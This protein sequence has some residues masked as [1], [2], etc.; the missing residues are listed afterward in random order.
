MGYSAPTRLQVIGEQDKQR[1]RRQRELLAEL[2]ELAGKS[3][4]LRPKDVAQFLNVN[5]SHI[6]TLVRNGQLP[7]VKVGG[8]Y[9]VPVTWFAEWL[10]TGGNQ[11]PELAAA[12]PACQPFGRRSS[13]KWAS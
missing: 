1:T 5:V 6:Y 10:A 13:R 3:S 4:T 7:H 8:V 11:D 9:R 2:E 12:L